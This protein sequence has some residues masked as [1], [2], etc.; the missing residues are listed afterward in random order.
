MFGKN[1][2]TTSEW[3]E[4]LHELRKLS[5]QMSTLRVCIGREC[6][7]HERRAGF[8]PQQCTKVGMISLWIWIQE[9]HRS[10][11]S[12]FTCR[13]QSH[14]GYLRSCLKNKNQKIMPID[15]DIAD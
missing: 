1:G 2:V 12:L 11:E 5:M 4:V 7:L 14:P 6:A 3:A 15:R 9:D 10:S 13:V 8:N